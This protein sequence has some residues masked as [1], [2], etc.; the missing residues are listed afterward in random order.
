[1]LLRK[2][3]KDL[4]VVGDSRI[5]NSVD[6]STM[7][8]HLNI[9]G[10][11]EI[12]DSDENVVTLEKETNPDTTALHTDH[13]EQLD[14]NDI[15]QGTETTTESHHI[16]T[17]A[18]LAIALKEVLSIT[19]PDMPSNKPSSHERDKFSSEDQ[20]EIIGQKTRDQ[21][22][23]MYRTSLLDQARHYAVAIGVCVCACV[24]V[25]VQ[26]A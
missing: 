13:T 15:V 9:K 18:D 3:T 22:N 20:L 14:K 8:D 2:N 19:V 25:C 11:K 4:F 7:N 21:L 17:N 5:N 24:R 1:M 26:Q 12:K 6:E 23:K 16:S 10:D